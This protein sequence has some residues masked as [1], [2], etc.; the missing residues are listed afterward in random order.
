MPKHFDA[1]VLKQLTNAEEIEIE[2][3]SPAGRTRRT[4]IWVIV[5]D[6]DVYVRSVRGRNGRWYQH[7]TAKPDAAIHIDGRH[8]AVHAVPVT[9]E[10]LIARVSN[11]Y[12][13]KYRDDP[14]SANSMV[15]AETLPTTLRLEPT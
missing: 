3:C 9:D 6:N 14:V 4:T 7:I 11:D 2:T 5:D 8:L 1:N 10:A 15:L 13:R 12:L